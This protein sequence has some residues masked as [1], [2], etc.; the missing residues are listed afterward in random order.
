MTGT[1]LGYYQWMF[2][3]MCVVDSAWLSLPHTVL[4]STFPLCALLYI[5]ELLCFNRDWLPCK[6]VW[7]VVGVGAGG[8]WMPLG[9]PYGNQP[10]IHQPAPRRR[11]DD[12]GCAAAPG[13]NRPCGPRRW[14]DG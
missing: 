14:M 9:A 5:A 13:Q 8:A 2:L 4:G 7:A 12:A 3:L 1:A 11:L 6:E 10:L